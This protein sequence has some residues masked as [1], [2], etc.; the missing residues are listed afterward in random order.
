MRRPSSISF[1]GDRLAT[2]ADMQHLFPSQM[3][4]LEPFT[5]LSYLAAA[6]DKIG[7]IGTVNTTYAEPYNI[8]RFTASLD[9]LSRAGPHGMS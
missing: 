3:T 9:H 5:M 7:L 4:R 6:T 1:P 8:A 2:S